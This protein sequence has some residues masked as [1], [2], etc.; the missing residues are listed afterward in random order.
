LEN[1]ISFRHF[2]STRRKL[3]AESFRRVLDYER[4]MMHAIEY[5]ENKQS[6]PDGAWLGG[7]FKLHAFIFWR[8]PQ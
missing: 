3:I 7:N 4:Y 8:L 2:F 6:A 5:F 1:N